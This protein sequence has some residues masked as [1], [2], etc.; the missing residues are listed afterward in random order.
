MIS[1]TTRIFGLLGFPVTHSFSPAMHNAAFKSL[2][3]PAEYRLFEIK[4]YD[5]ENFLLN[6]EA[7]ALDTEGSCVQAKDVVGFNI[8]IPY[9]V[10]AKEIIGKAY[11][12]KGVLDEDLSWAYASLIGSINTVKRESPRPRIW[13]SDAPG[14]V[15]SLKEDLNFEIAANK[16]TE[17]LV[18]GCGG[19]GRAIISA[20]TW[21]QPGIK[22]IYAYDVNS[23]TSRITAEYFSNFPT[24][25][26]YN[27][28]Y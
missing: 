1:Q 8:T 18:F 2:G 4:P 9:K 26:I 17:A 21:E 15:R 23:E 19:A 10:R 28:F 25:D 3:I 24:K 13:N 12:N 22:K 14:F 27:K 11:P 20:L 7:E 16:D 5:L 6:P